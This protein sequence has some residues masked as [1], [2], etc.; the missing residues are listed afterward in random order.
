MQMLRSQEPITVRRPWIQRRQKLRRCQQQR[1]L[2]VRWRGLLCS[3]CGRTGEQTVLHTGALLMPLLVRARSSAAVAMDML[4]LQC[5]CLDPKPKAPPLCCGD[6]KYKGDGVCDDANNNAGCEY[7]GGDCCVVSL[8]G[9]VNKQYC[10]Q[11]GNRFI[12]GLAAKTLAHVNAVT[13]SSHTV[14]TM[15]L[16]HV[17]FAVQVPGPEAQGLSIIHLRRGRQ[18]LRRLRRC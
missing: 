5:K 16:H 8:G 9:P 17:P 11:V 10:K 6:E 4:C 7:D 12:G 1:G 2:R 15:M 18:V 14:L 3:Q 13:N